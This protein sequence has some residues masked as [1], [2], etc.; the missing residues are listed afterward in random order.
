MTCSAVPAQCLAAGQINMLE[1]HND[2]GGKSMG[3]SHCDNNAACFQD[4]GMTSQ[5]HMQLVPV[6][7]SS[8]HTVTTLLQ[9][10]LLM[11]TGGRCE[12]GCSRSGE[13]SAA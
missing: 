10:Q 11:H 1:L 5:R 6:Q 13:C 9:L 8:K 12:T 4:T 2:W 3:P 7:G